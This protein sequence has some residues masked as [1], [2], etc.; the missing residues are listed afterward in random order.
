LIAPCDEAT[1]RPIGVAILLAS[2]ALG[3]STRRISP[4]AS[5]VGGELLDLQTNGLVPAGRSM[6]VSGSPQ[7]SFVLVPVQT[8]RAR[9]MTAMRLCRSHFL[10]TALF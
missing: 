1:R 8:T 10:R 2:T 5:S 7:R 9:P 4:P 6:R 3:P